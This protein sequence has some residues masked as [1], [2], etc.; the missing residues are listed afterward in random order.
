MN[1]EKIIIENRTGM[2][3]AQVIWYVKQ[4]M[5]NGRVSNNGENYCYVT[6]WRNGITV[7]ADKNKNSDKFVIE[8]EKR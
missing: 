1:A 6:T 8:L 2:P 5:E 7:Y 4:V 3:L